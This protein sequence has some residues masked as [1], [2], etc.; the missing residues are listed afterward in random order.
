MTPDAEVPA[1]IEA[2]DAAWVRVDTPLPASELRAFCEDVER[3]LRI[4]PMLEFSAF[5]RRGD[6]RFHVKARNLSNQTE[7][8]TG[9]SVVRSGDGIELRYDQGLRRRTVLRVDPAPGADGGATLVI[10]DDYSGWSESERRERAAEVD[11]SLVQWGHYLR[12][13]LLLWRRWSW[14]APWRWYM[15]RVWQP[16]TA[17]SRRIVY[18][19]LWITLAEILGVIIVVAIFAVGLDEVI[20]DWIN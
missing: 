12:E 4:N 3:L 13:Y 10:A 16:M 19:L 14:L 17:S 2:E 9:M 11:H 20:K 18:M 7:I 1:P 5:E 15:R 6:D 8:D